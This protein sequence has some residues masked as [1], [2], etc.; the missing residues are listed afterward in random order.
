M[1]PIPWLCPVV[2]ELL[3]FY[4]WLS[5][6]SRYC[7]REFSTESC[8]REESALVSPMAPLQHSILLLLLLLSS[9]LTAARGRKSR[10]RWGGY[11][12]GTLAILSSYMEAWAEVEMPVRGGSGQLRMA[13][14]DPLV[15]R[16]HR[17]CHLEWNVYVNE[18]VVLIALHLYLRTYACDDNNTIVIYV[19]Y[20]LHPPCH[21]GASTGGSHTWSHTLIPSQGG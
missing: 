10:L 11:G 9:R 18:C 3:S 16:H 1:L 12:G 19:F 15:Q 6:V 7:W 5:C 2:D 20:P 14:G 21:K 17:R 4:C 8:L 13:R